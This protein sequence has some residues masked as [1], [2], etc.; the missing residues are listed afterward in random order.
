MLARRAMAARCL[1]PVRLSYQLP[2]VLRTACISAAARHPEADRPI[3]A[4]ETTTR[5]GADRRCRRADIYG[6]GRLPERNDA[7]QRIRTGW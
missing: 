4:C 3:L 7:R 1:P 2:P 6:F 5:A